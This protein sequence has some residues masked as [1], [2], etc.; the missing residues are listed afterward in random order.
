MKGITLDEA[1][2]LVEGKLEGGDPSTEI[3]GVAPLS[4]AGS[5]DVTFFAN[6]HYLPALRK[7]R[8]AAALVPT[9][10]SEQITIPL[11]R[12]EN[13][14]LAF[15]KLM[16][17]FQP[18][19]IRFAPGIH[20]SAIV[21]ADAT[22]AESASIQPCAVIE[23][24]AVIGENVVIGAHCYIGHE[25]KIGDDTL[26]YPRVTIRERCLIGKRVILN[27]GV[28]IGGDGFGFEFQNGKHVKIPQIGIVQIDDDVEIGANSTVDRA[29]F[30]RTWIQQ[31]A[32]IDNLVMI[33]HN[34]VVGPHNIICGQVGISGSTR[35]GSY[36]TIAGQ[37][38]IVGH[39]EI[40][41]QAI[42]A[43]QTGIGHSIAPKEVYLGTPGEPMS[44]SKRRFV[45]TSRRQ[46]EK[47]LNRVKELEKRL[48]KSGISKE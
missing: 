40:G 17:V 24:G 23:S 3:Y 22:I 35:L 37:A 9:D 38:G 31:G 15:S 21:A 48:E 43:A 2:R 19:P 7:S 14:S 26:I 5:E 45:M 47:L 16:A 34:V 18:E 41:D 36:V 6:A 28:T 4:D 27:S 8:A 39:I 12:V 1:A 32:K 33:A 10:F 46:M 20:A 25:T 11:I 42:I 30:G 29:R 13:P 44:D